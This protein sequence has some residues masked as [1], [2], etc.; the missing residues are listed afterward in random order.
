[1]LFDQLQARCPEEIPILHR[2]TAKWDKDHFAPADAISH[3]L[4]AKAW[5]EAATLIEEIAL[6]EL[7]LFGEDSR[8]LRWLPDLPV[9]VVQQHKNLLFVYLQLAHMALPRERIESV[10]SRIEINLAYKPVTKQ[11]Q[12]EHEVLEEVQQIRKI[13]AQGNAFTPPLPSGT[14]REMSWQLLN[15]LHLLRANNHQNLDDLENRIPQFHESAI[16]FK[17]LFVILMSGGAYARRVAT[18]GKLKRG[19]KIAHQ[20]LQQAITL[21]G[22]FPETASVPLTALSQ[23]HY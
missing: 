22:S 13:W 14:N 21:R 10:I 7:E 4:A 15:G 16:E 20:A 12:E 3:L 2:K 6:R 17:N 8:L 9:N 23:I 11:T 1:M 18:N 5:E 19:E